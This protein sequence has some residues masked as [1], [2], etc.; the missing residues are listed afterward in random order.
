ME[1]D[2]P[3]ARLLQID[4]NTPLQLTVMHVL[5]DL[6]K[7][8]KSAQLPISMLTN[9]ARAKSRIERKTYLSQLIHL[10]DGEMSLDNPSRCH[11]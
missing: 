2:I 3:L 11:L 5:E 9:G 6:G 4:D 7:K 1:K 8:R 10:L